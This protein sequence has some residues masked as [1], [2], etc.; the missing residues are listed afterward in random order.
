[1]IFSLQKSIKICYFLTDNNH[2]RVAL[3]AFK[4]NL[5]VHFKCAMFD[6]QTFKLFIIQLKI[7]TLYSCFYV[8]KLWNDK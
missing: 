2:R 4:G 1:M 3:K 5:K 7:I 8:W 6:R